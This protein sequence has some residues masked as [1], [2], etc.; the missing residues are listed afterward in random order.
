MGDRQDQDSSCFGDTTNV[1]VTPSCCDRDN[2]VDMIGNTVEDFVLIGNKR[3]PK[4]NWQRLNDKKIADDNRRL[5]EHRVNNCQ[6]E[7]CYR[8]INKL[9]PEVPLREKYIARKQKHEQREIRKI[10]RIAKKEVKTGKQASIRN[11]FRY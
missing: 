4:L 3:L 10:K 2:A 9:P 7:V 1:Q 6:C 8:E 5:V 11:F